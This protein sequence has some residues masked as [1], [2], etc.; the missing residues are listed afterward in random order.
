MRGDA[1]ARPTRGDAADVPLP[2]PAGRADDSCCKHSTTGRMAFLVIMTSYGPDAHEAPGCHPVI[3]WY[4]QLGNCRRWRHLGRCAAA[5]SPT[6]VGRQCSS[7]AAQVERRGR[8]RV[9]ALH[10]LQTMVPQP[11]ATIHQGGL[12]ADILL[13]CK[14]WSWQRVCKDDA[15]HDHPV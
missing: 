12:C 8:S 10:H 9:G 2:P 7:G 15:A 6:A 13:W 3:L 11:I 14:P 4:R 5:L 1:P